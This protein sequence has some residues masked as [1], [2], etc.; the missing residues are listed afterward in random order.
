MKM[1]RLLSMLLAVLMVTSVIIGGGIVTAEETSP[2]TDVKTKRWSFADIMYVTENGLMNGTGEGI[3]A[4]AE[5]MTRAMVV[6]VL[7]RLQ[8]SPEVVFTTKFKDVK[9][10]K[11][12]TSAVI[13]AAEND[14]VN[15][16]GDGKF[17]PMETITR[18]QLAAIIM[19]YAPM[20]F[21]I[22]EERA[23]ITGY[24]DYKRV[25]DYAREALSWA[26]AVGLITGVT[27]TT[28]EPRK[29]ATREQFAAILRR[30]REYDSYKYELVYNAPVYSA[31][32]N[33][34]F[35]LVENANIYVAVDGNDS[36]PGTIDKPIATFAKAKEMVREL[37]STAKGG[38][39]VAFKAGEYGGLDNLT[40]T[41][42][43][44]GTADC[45]ITYTAYGDGEVIFSNGLIFGSEDFKPLDES[46]KSMFSEK[47][48]G[49][50]YKVDLEGKLDEITTKNVLFGGAGVCVEARYP[51]RNADGPDN[52]Y[53][54]CTTRVEEEGKEEHEYDKLKLSGPVV[55]IADKFSTYEGLKITGMFRTGWLIDT[56]KVKSYDKDNKILTL[57]FG[58]GQCDNGYPIWGHNSYP[59]AFEDRMDDTIF[60]HNL[61]ELLD[62]DGEYWFDT[63]TKRLYVYN[64]QG[65]YALS[66][67]GSFITLEEGADHITFRGFEFNASVDSALHI[68]SDYF[69]LDG[70]TIANIAGLK[71]VNADYSINHLTVKNCELY[72]FVCGGVIIR[73]DADLKQLIPAYNVVTNNYFHDF[74]LPQY[75]S[76]NTAVSISR[77][78]NAEISHNIFKNGAHAAIV[79]NDSIESF[80]EYNIFDN[81]MTTTMDYGAVYAWNNIGERSNHIRYNLFMNIKAKG[82][83]YSVYVDGA[84][85]QLVYGNLFYN[86]GDKA[87][88]LNG[89]R[90]NDIHDNLYV[91][92][93]TNGDFL[94]Y[95]EGVYT[96]IKD[97][98]TDEMGPGHW[99]FTYLMRYAPKEGEPGYD[100]WLAKWPIIYN[101]NIDPAKVGEY[102]CVYTIINYVKNNALFGANLDDC[103]E[104][105]EK[106]GVSE[107]NKFYTTDENPFF[108][109]PTHGDYT[110]V[111]GAGVISDEYLVDYSK[112]GL[113]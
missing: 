43:D 102:E 25:H 79:Y 19:R 26:N 9:K 61:A 3:F 48:V 68:K 11:W 87:V 66:K 41:A 105:Y 98:T 80:I 34:D 100:K 73:A 65:D 86:G 90:D 88:T 64:P 23:D 38:I 4:P 21:I 111:D 2:Y 50:I 45:P 82:G 113:Q 46:E 99:F 81:M 29:G 112:I 36:N 59:L 32:L 75:F 76:D 58:D 74:G 5:T 72:N 24:D 10:D 106:F 63:K 51:N 17:A 7:Y 85:G 92:T 12:F 103:G 28:L 55:K 109:D 1:R 8:G 96:H 70:C 37:K 62:D 91:K 78:V 71:A 56:F 67:G 104:M 108:A 15:G 83:A 52:K 47:V 33:R 31:T 60:F 97:G 95:N 22:T 13:W 14:I 49:D 16:V 89:G 77:D 69:T 30:F 40:F 18:E 39:V 44:A 27:D 107:N 93:Q 6:T 57:D 53:T 42:E 35:G 20:E 94:M 54:D 84:C 110:I 101:Y